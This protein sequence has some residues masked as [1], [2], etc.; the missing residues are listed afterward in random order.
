M[1]NLENAIINALSEYKSL[2]ISAIARECRYDR[3]AVARQL[4]IME[5]FGQVSKIEVGRAKKY[6]LLKSYPLFGLLDVSSDLVIVLDSDW[7]VQY[8]NK[9]AQT[10]FQTDSTPILGE[11]IDYLDLDIFCS[12]AV[13]EI[14]KR[15]KSLEVSRLQ[16]QSRTDADRRWFEVTIKKTNISSGL[17]SLFLFATDISQQMA[18]FRRLCESEA[19]YRSIFDNAPVP[20]LEEDFSG[21]KEYLTNLRRAGEGDLRSYFVRHPEEVMRCL[22]YIKMIQGNKKS[23]S[24]YQRD[25]TA[26]I[27]PDTQIVPYIRKESLDDLIAMLILLDQG[28]SPQGIEI[29]ILP[30]Q[31]ELRMYQVYISIQEGC[32]D[33]LSHLSIIF[34]DCTREKHLITS[35]AAQRN[36]RGRTD[37]TGMPHPEEKRTITRKRTD[38]FNRQTREVSSSV[39]FIHDLFDIKKAEYE[40]RRSEERYP[41]AG[42]E[43]TDMIIRFT[44]D[45]EITE[46]NEEFRSYISHIPANDATPG[47]DIFERITIVH[48]KAFFAFLHSFT[49]QQPVQE[50][51]HFI[52]GADGRR[53]W[54]WWSVQA[55]F[56]DAHD[57][58]GYLAEGRDITA[59]KWAEEA[60]IRSEYRLHRFIETT[61]DSVILID[62]EGRVIEWNKG[63]EKLTGIPKNDSMNRYIWDIFF[64]LTCQE[65]RTEELHE[66]LEQS[67]RSSLITGIPV[68]GE[69]ITLE[70]ERTDGER[71]IIR[72]VCFPLKT[73]TGFRFGYISQNVTPY[74]SSTQTIRSWGEYCCT[75]PD[76]SSDL[77]LAFDK[78]MKVSYASPTSFAV[79][80]FTPE[81]LV[82]KTIIF[83]ASTAFPD[84]GERLS[85]VIQAIIKGEPVD[86]PEIML[87]QTDGELR[88]ANLYAT[89]RIH[90]GGVTGAQILVRRIP[91][92]TMERDSGY[93]NKVNERAK[94]E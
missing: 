51:E 26:I 47:D 78:E 31:G 2:S 77:I 16:I 9:S 69:P 33:T 21:V 49:P 70:G 8:V 73:T 15:I 13:I 30:P 5:I 45:G 57:P 60:V 92:E 32:Q 43:Q 75:I 20:I 25:Q 1:K 38:L 27:S 87:R 81:E 72:Q 56:D 14:L 42:D 90:E 80:G 36:G 74:R 37:G 89:P 11:R 65:Q 50:I 53:Y 79:L 18:K 55:L 64:R 6:L 68:F 28:V 4:E 24:L 48:K 66:I 12:P 35:Q 61:T 67:F 23:H 22:S 85:E 58:Y 88:Y 82:G 3:H 17:Y 54:Q 40:L 62:E 19:C 39:E 29:T 44:P 84:S 34:I 7:Y 10:Y 86:T 83:I 71:L 63:S 76:T 94:G 41:R 93:E 59:R 52:P 46:M 91:P